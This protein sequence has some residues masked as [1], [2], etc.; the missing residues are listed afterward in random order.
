[1]SEIISLAFQTFKYHK[2]RSFLTTLSIVIGVTTVISILS[3]IEGF[4]QAVLGEIRSLGS[5]AISLTKAPVTMVSNLNIEK[6]ARL[7]DLTIEDALAIAKL[8]SVEVVVP[9]IVKQIGEIKYKGKKVMQVTVIG[10]TA[11]YFIAENYAIEIGRALSDEDINHR[12]AVCVIGNSIYDAFFTE[13]NVIGKDLKINSHRVKVLG[14]LKKKGTI[15][16]KN[17]DNVI[18]MPY[19]FFEKIF[20]SRRTLSPLEWAS[21]TY[22]IRIKPRP[23]MLKKTLDAVEEVMRRR[24]GLKYDEPN[25]FGLVTQEI[26]FEMYRNV[27]RVGFIAIVAIAAISLIVGG[28]GIMNIMLV[29]V[30]ERTREIGIHKTVGASNQNILLQFITES[31]VLTLIGG[32]IGIVLGIILAWIVS[33]VS[34]LKAAIAPWMILL[35]FGFSSATGVFFGIYPAHKAASL[36]PIEALR[37]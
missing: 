35:G 33:T 37:F 20:K 19:T 34:P 9:L 36:N 22:T 15:L 12:R 27:T 8:P 13:E 26:L 31:V 3:L 28:I 11:E 21:F 5:D 30:A 14:V 2:L 7:P 29:S 23:M 1:M 6:I 16:G 32:V 4:N 10:T 24:R 25:N 18:I 17:L